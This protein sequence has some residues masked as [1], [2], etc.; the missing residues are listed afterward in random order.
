MRTS[1]YNVIYDGHI[2]FTGT[3][4]EVQRWCGM[5]ECT[6]LSYYITCG[7]KLCRKYDLEYAERPEPRVLYDFYENGQW[8]FQGTNAEFKRR[9]CPDLKGSVSSY[10]AYN[11]TICGRFKAYP[12]KNDKADPKLKYL[13][14]HL[15]K[16]GNTVSK[17]DPTQYIEQLKEQDINCTIR[18]CVGRDAKRRKDVYYIIE[19]I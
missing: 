8:I 4:R 7:S 18:K 9:F 17:K 6:R 5:S 15:T 13:V 2:I 19:C 3:E 10:V 11:A 12:V 16:Y 1:T 14:E